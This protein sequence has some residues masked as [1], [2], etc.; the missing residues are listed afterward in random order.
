MQSGYSEDSS[1]EQVKYTSFFWR[2]I[3]VLNNQIKCFPIEFMNHK[4]NNQKLNHLTLINSF[5]GTKGRILDFLSSIKWRELANTIK[6]I[7]TIKYLW[8]WTITHII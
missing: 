6:S 2:L 5:K 7:K 3:R 4:S 1:S 8:K